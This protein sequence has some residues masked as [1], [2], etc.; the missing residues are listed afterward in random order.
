MTDLE[1][2]IDAAIADILSRASSG[3]EEPPP[4]ETLAIFK[5]HGLI[6]LS[7][8]DVHAPPPADAWMDKP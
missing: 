8:A 5:R 3:P 2:R 6:I 7:V 1:K 4:Q